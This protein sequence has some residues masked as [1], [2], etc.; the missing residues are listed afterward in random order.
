M[1]VLNVSGCLLGPQTCED[2]GNTHW[3]EIPPTFSENEFYNAFKK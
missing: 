3:V 2:S 1:V